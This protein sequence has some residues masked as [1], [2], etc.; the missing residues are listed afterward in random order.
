MF[1][2]RHSRN[3]SPFGSDQIKHRVYTNFFWS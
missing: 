2:E 1:A 3:D